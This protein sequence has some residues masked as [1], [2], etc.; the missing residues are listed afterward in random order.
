MFGFQQNQ[1]FKQVSRAQLLRKV[2]KMQLSSAALNF[3]KGFL[4][5]QIS[6]NFCHKI[7]AKYQEGSLTEKRADST[8]AKIL[9]LI[10]NQNNFSVKWRCTSKTVK[11]L[12]CLDQVHII[13]MS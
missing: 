6:R 10:I 4:N 11:I 3:A 12:K 7:H 13:Q 1:L 9:P 5:K 8:C 2:W